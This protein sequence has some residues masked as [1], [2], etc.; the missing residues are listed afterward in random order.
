M[1]ELTVVAY[2]DLADAAYVPV[3][4]DVAARAAAAE[5]LVAVDPSAEE[6]RVLGS[7]TYVTSG[8]YLEAAREP[9]EVGFRMLAVDP[10]VQRRGV[11]RALVLA[12]LDRARAAGADRVVISTQPA[13]HAAH[14]LY[15]A[16]GF[17]R[18]PERDWAPL[19]T[20]PLWVLGLDLTPPG[21]GGAARR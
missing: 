6:E 9:D 15:A 21:P 3:L 1:A 5:V 16:L 11:A 19:P 20:V 8:P 18:L 7:V 10:A 13:M 2:G 12:C 17:R 4:A 14:R